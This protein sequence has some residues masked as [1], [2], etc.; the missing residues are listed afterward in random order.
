MLIENGKMGCDNGFLRRNGP[1]RC[2]NPI[3]QKGNRFGMLEYFQALC[4]VRR[5][6][7]WMK[8]RLIG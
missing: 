7:D 1:I 8:L 5:Q 4:D 6:F 2:L 3:A